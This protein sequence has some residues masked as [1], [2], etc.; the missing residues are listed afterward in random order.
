MAKEKNWTWSVFGR[1]V[2]ITDNTAKW[3]IAFGAR[4]GPSVNSTPPEIVHLQQH[5][6]QMAAANRQLEDEN[7]ELKKKLM[8][9]EGFS[10]TAAMYHGPGHQ[11]RTTC[12]RNDPHSL[13]NEH[14]AA[15]PM[16]AGFSWVGPKG[17]D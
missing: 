15:N 16:E 8:A 11:S 6:I 14:Y 10:C 1:Q 13:D 2:R 3:L 5:I 12:E 9:K 17:V 4:K 7:R